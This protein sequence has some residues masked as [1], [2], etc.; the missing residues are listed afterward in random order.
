MTAS[1]SIPLAVPDLRGNETRYLAECV[2][3]NWVST[4]GP[5]VVE[6][7]NRVAALTGRRFAV[8]TVNGTTAIQ[9]AL[10]ASGVRPGD[11]VIVPD[12]TFAASAAAIY[13]AGAEAYFVDVSAES[14]T[15][16]PNL[17]REALKHAPRKVGAV[18]AVHACG[19][20]ADMDP[21][22]AACD[23]AGVPLLED[24]A[25]A[26]GARYKGRPAG[27]FG[28]AA[29]F[30]FNGNKTVTAGGGGMVMTDDERIAKRVRH[31]STTER[32]GA[33]YEHDEVGFNFRMTNLNA[34]V[35]VA[36]LER[37]DEMIRA[38]KAIA[39]RYDWAIKNRSDLA[40]M[41]RMP[42][43]DSSCWLYNLRTSSPDAA[44]SLVAHL[45]AR[46]I[47]ARTFWLSLSAQKPYAAAPR[48][49]SGV[50][51]RLLSG[52]C[53]S[54][55]CSSH[56]GAADQARVIEAANDWRSA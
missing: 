22:R 41:P 46:Q 14:W 20:P 26:I 10:T 9:L 53:V 35:G 8:A 48:L 56:L 37:L 32:I 38:K 15:I 55:P 27:S 28:D 52:R 40:A 29:I 47:E 7:E 51:E 43:A 21:I 31:L 49:L 25:G 42:W 54:L 17:I 44:R 36:Q 11:L 6:M 4:A 34:A 33:N 3:D 12:W 13:H 2:A 45:N 39:D 24:A 19:H 18:L 50:A 23:A 30:S 5:R 16:D 1:R